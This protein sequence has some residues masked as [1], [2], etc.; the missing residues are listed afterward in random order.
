MTRDASADPVE[1]PRRHPERAEVEE[2]RRRRIAVRRREDRVRD[3]RRRAPRPTAR[4]APGPARRADASDRRAG[5]EAMAART[6]GGAMPTVKA[7]PTSHS[8]AIASLRTGLP[9]RGRY[10]AGRPRARGA[11]RSGAGRGHG[12]VADDPSVVDLDD[13]RATSPTKRGSWVAARRHA[14]PRGAPRGSRST[15]RSR[16]G[17][18]RMSARRGRAPRVPHER[19]ASDSRRGSPPER[20]IRARSPNLSSGIAAGPSASGPRPFP[21]I[22]PEHDLVGHPRRQELPLRLLEDVRGAARRGRPPAAERVVACESDPPARS[23]AAGPRAAGQGRLAAA[24]RADE[25]DTFT[26]PHLEVDR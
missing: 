17:P 7:R 13:A 15:P 18:V 2:R 9:G 14:P 16:A 8:T 20:R 1:T 26:G 3:T 11:G 23:A 6:R 4:R 5:H 19:Q 22:E 21:R 25:R 12:R 10:R 24:V